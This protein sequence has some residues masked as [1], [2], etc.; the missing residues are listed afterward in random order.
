ML[1]LLAYATMSQNPVVPTPTIWADVPDISVVRAGR[2][3]YMS[4]TTMHMNPGVPIMKSSDLVNWRIVS[5]CYDDLGSS[6]RQDLLDG[7]NEYGK[8]TWASSLRFHNGTFYCSTFSNTTG[9]TYIF[10]TKTPDKGPWK[11]IEFSP[12]IHDHSL[13]F[14]E[15]KA[16]LIHGVGKIRIQELKDDLS[17]L[18]PGGIDQ[19]IIEDAAAPTGAKTGLMGEGSQLFK[20][21]SKYYLF[22]IVWPRGGMRTQVVHRSDSLL[23]PYEGRVFLADQG[24]AQGGIVDTPDG[25]WYTNM[26]GDRGAVGRIPYMLPMHWEDGWPVIGS[27]ELIPHSADLLPGQADLKGIVRSDEF[28]SKKLAIEWQW[29]HNPDPSNWSVSE[30]PGWLRIRTCRV[31]PIVTQARNTLTQRTFGPTCTGTVR[32]D[33][34]NLKDGDAAGIVA[35]MG[36]YGYIGI[37]RNGDIR[38]VVVVSG[39][40]GK[41]K[42]VATVPLSEKVAY[43]RMACDFRNQADLCSFSF[44]RDGRNWIMLGEPIKLRYELSHFMGC[45]FGLF[46]MATIQSGGHADFDFFRISA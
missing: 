45:R 26:F 1:T 7:K 46:N 12:A 18:K 21:N 15:G 3:Y 37:R 35:L 22:N 2:D 43:L 42:L 27:G 36:K 6:P 13:V 30:R 17:G 40:S 32:L 41:P 14:D 31:D 34:S 25:R 4:S 10:S 9:K 11:K 23:G 19:V 16:Y 39:T 44:S 8:G 5:Y 38:E 33:S 24:I 20:V 29:N 28:R